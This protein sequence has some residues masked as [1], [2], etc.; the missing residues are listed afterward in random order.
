M[1]ARAQAA[2]DKTE[3]EWTKLLMEERAKRQKLELQKAEASVHTQIHRRMEHSSQ[4]EHRIAARFVTFCAS[5][6]QRKPE[7]LVNE[8]LVAQFKAGWAAPLP[9]S[10]DGCMSELLCSHGIEVMSQLASSYARLRHLRGQD[11]LRFVWCAESSVSTN[12]ARCVA[13]RLVVSQVS[14]G[15]QYKVRSRMG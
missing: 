9:P 1:K 4:P 10:A 2:A 12:F 11:W 3:I 6:A 7:D 13:A 14:A 5:F 8:E 15:M